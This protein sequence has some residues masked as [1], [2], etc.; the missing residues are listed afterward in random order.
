MGAAHVRI[1]Q[2]PPHRSSSMVGQPAPGGDQRLGRY[3]GV[4]VGV[5]VGARN[6][7]DD[8]VRPLGAVGS[9]DF[10]RVSQ[11]ALGQSKDR[12]QTP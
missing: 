8:D 6:W 10:I 11:K 7:F 2:L 4:G 12:L 5:G 9:D 3:A 1:G